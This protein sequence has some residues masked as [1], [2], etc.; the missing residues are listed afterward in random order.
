M[1]S[2]LAIL[3]FGILRLNVD[4]AGAEA[5]PAAG[6]PEA[7]TLDVLVFLDLIKPAQRAMQC[8]YDAV[9]KQWSDVI[10]FERD[11]K[12]W[13]TESGSSRGWSEQNRNAGRWESNGTGVTLKWSAWPPEQL[14]TQDGGRTF[15]C[16][17]GYQFTLSLPVARGA[18]PQWLFGGQSA[19]QVQEEMQRLLR[20]ELDRLRQRRTDPS[21]PRV[22]Q[23][24]RDLTLRLK[25]FAKMLRD[26]GKQRK[27]SR[28]EQVPKLLKMAFD[29]AGWDVH[30]NVAA[31]NRTAP[32][33]A[34]ELET[35]LL[36][37]LDGVGGKR[38]RD[39]GSI[40]CVGNVAQPAR[41]L[42]PELVGYPPFVA[43]QK[44][45]HDAAFGDCPTSV[46]S[47]EWCSRA[48]PSMGD[49]PWGLQVLGRHQTGNV[50][51]NYRFCSVS[52]SD[53]SCAA[54]V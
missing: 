42:P 52:Y 35:F 15:Q 16:T 4:R 29:R 20:R 44:A 45:D 37:A 26:V 28:L 38:K 33:N 51:Q 50:L 11:G 49:V 34:A 9:H 25:P 5:R 7:R 18:V 41:E 1:P 19:E 39:M 48:E 30:K 2:R 32:P 3:K 47:P 8:A 53:R 13:R 43:Q 27:N 14:Q 54:L 40:G 23:L 22:V 46:M 17:R 24:F 31:L 21:A 36:S 10:V 12:F 6:C